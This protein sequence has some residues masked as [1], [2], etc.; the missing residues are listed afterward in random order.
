MTENQKKWIAA[1]RS[2][3]FKQATNKLQE[4]DCYCC[5]GVGCVVA[6]RGGVQVARDGTGILL[7][8]TLERQPQAAAWLGLYSLDGFP[9]GGRSD[10]KSLIIYNDKKSFAEI[11][12]II[13]AN[14]VAYFRPVPQETAVQATA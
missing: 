14:P 10:V 4:G 1:L 6:E 11:A 12:D 7:G 5:L 13:E 2:G 9:R 3:E 8:E